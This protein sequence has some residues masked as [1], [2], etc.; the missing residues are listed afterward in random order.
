MP[1][2]APR[3]AAAGTHGRETPPGDDLPQETAERMSDHDR[4]CFQLPDDVGVVV[5]H[6]RNRL[7]CKD[8]WVSFRLLHRRRVIWPSWRQRRV[9]GLFEDGGPAVPAAW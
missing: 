7:V 4:L 8:L 5:G 9:A 1:T 2:S 3:A 6:L